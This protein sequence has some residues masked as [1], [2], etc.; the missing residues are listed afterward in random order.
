MNFLDSLPESHPLVRTKRRA[1]RIKRRIK[2]MWWERLNGREYRAWLSDSL[3]RPAGSIEN[4]VPIAV[5]VPVFNPP[6]RFLES[7][8][9]SVVSQ[10][11]RNWQLIVSNDGSTDPSV[12]D[13]LEDFA[14]RHAQDPRI[15]VVDGPNGGIAAAC[16]RGLEQVSTQWFGWLDHD[17]VL[18]P[19]AFELFSQEL[20]K[21]PN[22]LVI[23]SDED[24]IDGSDKHFELYCKPDYSPELLLT[25]MY[26]CHF[27]CFRT[28]EVR[29]VGGFRSQFDGAQDFDLALRLLPQLSEDNVLHVS[30]P[31]YH[32][33]AWAQS[34]ALTIDAKP[35]AQE[36]SARA[37]QGHLD[38]MA[39]GTVVASLVPGLNEVH[40]AVQS[41]PLV[42]VIIPTAGA[43]NDQGRFVD[44]AVASLREHESSVPLE[45]IAVTTGEISPING[46]DGQVVLEPPFNF[47]RAINTGRRHSRGEFLFLLNDDTSVDSDQ[48]VLRLLEMASDPRVGVVGALLRYPDGR[49]QHA[50]IV[51]LPTGPTHAHIARPGSFP[52]YFGSTLTPRNFSAVTAAA[53]LIR[54]STFDELD[55]FD[56]EF[57]RDFND[58][59]FCLRARQAG[60]RIAW[61]PYAHLTH[62]EGAS[63]VRKKADPQEQKLFDQRWGSMGVDPYYSPALHH[64]LNRLY[65]A[66]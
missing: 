1:G 13:F 56:T 9:N 18:N 38:R 46:V 15:V 59:D 37:Q 6:V 29:A 24:K 12:R 57:A 42:S 33:R 35:W 64:E 45:I 55:G 41:P 47:S 39:G 63:I 22:T 44:A 27:T 10:T 7:C 14:T 34:T 8:L 21:N 3:D 40:P 32:W 43:A 5:V 61:T 50:G 20:S 66:R 65:E 2:R 62:H 28:R 49:I 52:G 36:A 48:P 11:A 17:D 23:Y 26:L 60:Y 31:L 53:M 16:N 25:Q 19:R 4:E 58:V 51:M 54:A 30:R